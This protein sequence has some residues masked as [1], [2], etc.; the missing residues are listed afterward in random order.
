[1]Q[2]AGNPDTSESAI[3]LGP[4]GLTFI[5]STEATPDQIDKVFK[6]LIVIIDHFLAYGLI[7]TKKL[8]DEKITHYWQLMTKYFATVE[9]VAFINETMADKP[10]ANKAIS[11]IIVCLNE[12]SVLN[13]VFKQIFSNGSFLSYYN[14]ESSYLFLHRAQLL[15]ISQ[16]ISSQ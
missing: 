12:H 16:R 14:E 10:D 2:Y 3:K 11:W 7:K 6:N 9:S 15:I 13:D 4:I 1:M 8:D 5:L